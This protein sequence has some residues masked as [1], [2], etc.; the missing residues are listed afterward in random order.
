MESMP[1]PAYTVNTEKQGNMQ[2]S[3]PYPEVYTVEEFAQMF[4]LSAEVVRNLI[5]R[6]EIAAIRIGKQYRIPQPVVDRYFAQALPP[7]ERGF[8]MWKEKPVSSLSYV[9]RLRER[10]SRSPEAFLAD[11]TQDG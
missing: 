4:K 11:L 5:R 6:G 2:K 1:Y 8:G 9:N 7:Q 10:D 3:I